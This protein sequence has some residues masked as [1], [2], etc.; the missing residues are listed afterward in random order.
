MLK[1]K[2]KNIFLVVICFGLLMGGLIF[3]K[4]NFFEDKKKRFVE[5]KIELSE[6][7]ITDKDCC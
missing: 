4:V 3:I 2:L 1:C 6:Y 7:V 5:K